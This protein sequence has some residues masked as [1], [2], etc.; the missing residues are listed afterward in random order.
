MKFIADLHIHSRYSIATSKK[1]VPEY[2]DYWAK[3]K[4]INIVGTGD[5][6]HPGWFGE[7]TEKLEPV[8][9]GLYRLKDNVPLDDPEL[10]QINFKQKET[11][12]ILSTE[13]SSIYKKGDKVRKVHNL[14]FFPDFEA[15]YK[16][17]KRLEKIGNIHSDGRPILGLDS[18]NLL[19]MVLETNSK[20]FLIPAHIWT[21]WFSVLGSKSGFD[22]IEECFEDLTPEIFAVETGLSSDPPMNWACSFLDKFRLV[23]NSD[24]HSPE[25]LGRE[26][27]LFDSDLS[28]DGIYNSLKND[29]GFLGTVEFFPQEGKYH[30]DGHRKCGICWDPLKTLAHDGC[31]PVCQKTL[32][33]GVMYR[34]AELADR[35]NFSDLPIKKDFYSLT[36]L[37]E[38]IAEIMGKRSNSK[39]VKREYWEMIEKLGSEFDILLSSSLKDLKQVGGDIFAEGIRRLRKG[40]VHIEEGFDGE[41]GHINMF[42]KEE[43][44]D[45]KYASLFPSEKRKIK[46]KK[47]TKKEI[48]SFNIA[49]FQ[50]I[51]KGD[52]K[53]L[54]EANSSASTILKLNEKQIEAIEDCEGPCL[55]LAGPG[56]GKTR[57][58][59]ERIIYLMTHYHVNSKNILAITFS[60]KA[61]EE[62]KD[63]VKEKNSET[64]LK[65]STFHAFGLSI[66]KEHY[67]IV[68]RTSDFY[69]IDE[70]DKKEIIEQIKGK[71]KESSAKTIKTIE[72]Y[73][74]GFASIKGTEIILKAYEEKL[75]QLNA[76][77]LDDLIFL[78]V[79][80]FITH[81]HILAAYQKQYPWILID[82][83]QDI[84]ARQ[85]EMISLIAIKP[86]FNI[87][88]IGDPD[89][90]IY[91]FRG[92][93]IKFIDKIQK[94]YPD[95]RI[96]HLDKS[97]RCPSPI[98]KAAGQ[99]LKKKSYLEGKEDNIKIHIESFKTEK[100]EADF[101]AAQIEKMIG[102]VRSFSI[103]SGISDGNEFKDIN[104]FSDF[105][106]LCRSSLLFDSF[107][108]AFKN[109]GI[110]YQII[111][112]KP[113]YQQEPVQKIIRRFRQIY[114][115]KKG[116]EEISDSLDLEI[117]ELIK[118]QKNLSLILRRLCVAYQI[119]EENVQ[120]IEEFSTNFSHNYA[121][122]FQIINTRQGIDDFKEKKEAVSLMTIHAA[123]GLE[124]KTVFIPACEDKLIPFELFGKK[125]KKE[126]SEEE[127]LFYVGITRSK[128][129]LFLT[130]S[131]KRFF[132]NRV[133]EQ[134]PSPLL[135]RLQKKLF[136]IQ[137]RALKKNRPSDLQLSLFDH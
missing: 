70:D 114:Y 44:D 27:N 10:P 3:V 22:T 68:G 80:I 21:P 1:L 15:A 99:I 65:I 109:H 2:L 105:A 87:F 38:I 116:L 79:Q 101:V 93:D 113:F 118:Q 43:I 122:F 72:S 64:D 19:E 13:I 125:N 88:A 103:D 107:V 36:A 54:D 28:Y 134:K 60:N 55:V 96:I 69:I 95:I 31:C 50:A 4:G 23:S 81:P 126:L 128:K 129:Y 76:F 100:S 20:S 66:L 131:E 89:Q 92:S 41:F 102:G 71:G 47:A 56:S 48:I 112:L 77:D 124:F 57:I 52:K 111:G 29:Q 132:K 62:I 17:Q 106:I 45:L 61:C 32:T 98:L 104:S 74:Q 26:V 82:E 94:D 5:C 11:F 91:G 42:R 9:N 40:E 63:R 135:N 37:S 14:C 119:N 25:K 49:Q 8:G 18:K 51:N 84:N 30:Y 6:I 121:R 137:Q 58:L 53:S 59:T 7:L 33:K 75:E 78:P 12:F 67:Q 133:L 97:Y 127:R 85:Y 73:K 16:L 24:A 39:I 117:L 115:E 120:K 46:R 123:K 35:S 86:F 90:A 108:T 83:Y 130:H 136:T 34:V 110:A